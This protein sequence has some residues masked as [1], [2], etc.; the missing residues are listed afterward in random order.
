MDEVTAGFDARGQRRDEGGKPLSNPTVFFDI[1]LDGKPLGRLEMVLRA[2]VVP[3]TA[4]N[5]RAL[6]TG[7]RGFGFAGSKFHRIIPGF[8]CQGGDFTAHNG[9]GGRS[10]YGGKFKDENFVLKHTGPGVLSMANS[11]P[12]TNGSQFFICT[13]RTEHLD[14]KHVVFGRVSN[15]YDEVVNQMD[16]VG[17]RSGNPRAQV[18]IVRCGEISPEE[19]DTRR[20]K[21]KRDEAN[22]DPRNTPA[23]PAGQRAPTAEEIDT[24]LEEAEEIEALD[25]GAVKRL[26]LGLEKKLTKNHEMRMKYGHMP[27][28]FA[29]SEVELD[30][31]IKK[32]HELAT[33]PDLYPTLVSVNFHSSLAELLKH[34]NVDVAVDTIDL[35]HDLLDPEML[36]EAI[37]PAMTLV[38]NLIEVDFLTL[39]TDNLDR[40][41]ES[42]EDQ[43]EAVHNVLGVVENLIELKPDLSEVIVAQ[44]KIL[45]FLLGRL[46]SAQSKD[47]HPNKLYASEVLS[48]LLQASEANQQALAKLHGVDT[49]LVAAAGYKRKDPAG[50]EEQEL[51]E[52]IFVCLCSALMTAENKEE[53]RKAEGIELMLLIMRE[54][55]YAR[56]CAVKVLDFVLTNDAL[57]CERCVDAG[58]LK[59]VFPVFMGRALK[60]KYL[61]ADEKQKMEQLGVSLLGSLFKFCTGQRLER[62][63]LKFEENGCEKVDRACELFTRYADKMQA[64][65]M[66]YAA[67]D[68]KRAADAR[69]AALAADER[70]E[71]EAAV[72]DERYLE[73]MDAGLYTLQLLAAIL[74]SIWVQDAPRARAKLLLHQQSIEIAEVANVLEEL[75]SSVEDKPQLSSKEKPLGDPQ[76]DAN[77][78]IGA[79][80]VKAAEAASI[81]ALALQLAEQN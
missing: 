81:R 34:E 9:T 79:A 69:F 30:D 8:M 55:K 45:T 1:E 26:V 66:R 33:A 49:L 6:C 24:L 20:Q 2:D 48:M 76:L 12:N 11:G 59:S 63:L 73:R 77:T 5:F 78:A 70:A 60:K 72:Q 71:I 61:D 67:Q 3:K 39:L 41:E 44:T 4:E 21:R 19:P 47:F 32:L 57:S 22:D 74:A 65:K 13:S 43:A 64:M 31:E 28:Q 56:K 38:E 29:K 37:Q 75:A 23:A 80:R 51:C 50:E 40:L 36:T 52:N 7:E 10:I 46:G 17:S 25:E 14:N 35:L 42:D 53:F 18:T 62:L 27:A 15:G 58:G 16:G 68:A 54:K